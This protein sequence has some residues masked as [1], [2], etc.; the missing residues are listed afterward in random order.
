MEE[1]QPFTAPTSV[2]VPSSDLIN[3][4]FDQSDKRFEEMGRKL[5]TLLLQN[6]HFLDEDA[7]KSLVRDTVKPINDQLASYRWYLRACF[8]AAVLAFCS[9]VMVVFFHK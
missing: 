3:Y 1:H 9:A 4:R 5:D 6:A 2:S 7:V 8:S